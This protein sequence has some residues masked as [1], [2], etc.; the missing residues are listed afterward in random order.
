MRHRQYNNSD[1]VGGSW[2]HLR[3][4]CTLFAQ[5]FVFICQTNSSLFIRPPPPHCFRLEFSTFSPNPPPKKKILFIYLIT[6][7]HYFILREVRQLFLNY[8]INWWSIDSNFIDCS[9]ILIVSWLFQVID[10]TGKW[11]QPIRLSLIFFFFYYL[12]VMMEISV[13]S[14]TFYIFNCCMCFFAASPRCTSRPGPDWEMVAQ[15]FFFFLLNVRLG[16]VVLFL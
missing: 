14:C 8:L 5:S 12:S 15:L 11:R 10:V 13:I 7:Q 1:H 3:W 6:K 2:K 4:S 9:L 16:F